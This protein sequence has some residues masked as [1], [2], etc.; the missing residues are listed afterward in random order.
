MPIL[1]TSALPGPTGRAASATGRASWPCPPGCRRR[2]VP[3][4][5]IRRP[6]RPPDTVASRRPSP[7]AWMPGETT[8]PGIFRP[9]DSAQSPR[10]HGILPSSERVG[11]GVRPVFRPRVHGVPTMSTVYLDRP[12]RRPPSAR[13]VAASA[14]RMGLPAD[15]AA[16]A[17]RS[18]H[19]CTAHGGPPL[20]ADAADRP[21]YV[22]GL[23][24]T[25]VVDWAAVAA[26]LAAAFPAGH[27][28]RAQYD[29]LDAC[30]L[31]VDSAGGSAVTIWS[32]G[33]GMGV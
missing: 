1:S 9:P 27:S 24:F 31:T 6:R 2:W 13:A 15:A 25:S 12:V 3:R 26:R 16:P 11:R 28:A 7:G 8:I 33:S 29:R 19:D 14:R 30:T 32:P 17:R 20:S 10:W 21:A 23:R 5:W 22:N 18:S 4:R